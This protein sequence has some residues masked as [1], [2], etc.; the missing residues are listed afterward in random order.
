MDQPQF[1]LLAG[2]GG[3]FILEPLPAGYGHTLGNALRRVLYTSIAGA[4]ITSVK[5]AGV[6]HQFSTL[7]GVREDVVQ[8]ILA[9][10]Q[11][12][13]KLTA[14]KAVK[15]TLVVKGPGEVKA[16]D[17]V[18]PAQVTI[19]NPSLVIAHLADKNAKLDIEATVEGGYGYSPAEER[20]TTTLGVIPVDATFT[21]VTRVNYTVEAT[22]VGRM[23][24]YDKLVLEITTDGT[25][26]PQAALTAA[27]ETLVNYFRAV[28]TPLPTPAV[29]A[30]QSRQPAAGATLAIEELDLPTRIANALQKAGLETVASV[31]ATPRSQL[32]KIKNLGTKS[33]KVIELALADRGFILPA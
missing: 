11:V 16:G 17:F 18:T 23:T 15:V 24:N 1:T 3:K 26:T 6:R 20:P 27:A 8:L 25:I 28:V 32:V 7:P 22:R 9:L 13:L 4:A 19:A 21:P 29:A 12:R 10:K 14:D 31:L 5:V 30:G 33:V 2:P